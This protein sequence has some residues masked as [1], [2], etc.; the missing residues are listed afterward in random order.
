MEKSQGTLIV[1]GAVGGIGRAIAE[2]FTTDFSDIYTGVFNV[3]NTSN[4]NAQLLRNTLLKAKNPFTISLL[5]LTSLSNIRS[6]ATDINIRV[7]T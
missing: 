1:T 5:E 6:F 4:A 7:S 3:R 2:R